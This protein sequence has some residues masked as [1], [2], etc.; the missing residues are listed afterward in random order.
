M[1]KLNMSDLICRLSFLSCAMMSG[2]LFAE[3]VVEVDFTRG[4]TEWNIRDKGS[5][6]GPLPDRVS[7]DFP[8]WNTSQ[9]ISK[10]VS[11]STGSGLRLES[12]KLDYLIL[13]RLANHRGMPFP[14]Y[15]RVTVR[16]RLGGDSAIRLRS[17]NGPTYPTYAIV[18]L[19]FSA[20]WTTRSI[21][22][23]AVD[24]IGG[25]LPKSF[26]QKGILQALLETGTRPIELAFLRIDTASR[27]EYSKFVNRELKRPPKYAGNYLRSSC[28]PLGIPSGWRAVN[29]DFPTG[30]P[31]P[32]GF[33]PLQLKSSKSF[34]YSA[35]FLAPE[36]VSRCTLSFDCRGNGK[37]YVLIVNEKNKPVNTSN[38]TIPLTDSWTRRSI[39]FEVSEGIRGYSILMSGTAQVDRLTVCSTEQGANYAT[40]LRNEVAL[41]P[42]GGKHAAM[43]LH[44]IDETPQ[45]SY[46]VTG[47]LTP[48]SILKGKVVNLYGE[49]R[50]LPDIALFGH[51]FGSFDYLLFPEKQLGPFRI[52]AWVEEKGRKSSPCGELVMTRIRRPVHENHD[53]PN[54]PFGNHVNA[55]QPRLAA[56][57]AAGV[58]HIRLHDALF[59]TVWSRMEA[60]KGKWTFDDKAIDEYRREHLL[61]L[62]WLGGTPRWAAPPNST[63][64]YYG[65]G[66][67]WGGY[68]SLRDEEAFRNYVRKVV[69][70][71][72]GRIHEWDCWNEPWFIPEGAEKFARLQKAACEEIKKVA[73]EVKLVGFNTNAD[74]ANTPDWTT[75]I[76]QQGG[77]QTCD[78][79]DYHIYE[80]SFCGYPGDT[81]E[82]SFRS[83]WAGVLSREKGK[84]KPIYMSEGNWNSRE[85]D[86]AGMYLHSITWTGRE[87]NLE[88]SNGLVRFHLGLL[89]AGCSRIYLYSDQHQQHLLQWQ[90]YP[91][92]LMNDGY[93]RPTL[94]AYSNMAYLLE[95]RTITRK[96]A[97]SNGVWAIWFSG[98]GKT[99]AVI[100]GRQSAKWSGAFPQKS[101]GFD[102]FGNPLTGTLEYRDLVFYL[103]ADSADQELLPGGIRYRP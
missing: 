20:D 102:L 60:E 19:P 21:P 97:L 26:Q 53:A 57:K 83:A 9:A 8:K 38:G 74:Y 85:K 3:T 51:P 23:V 13:F 15:Y 22:V 93:P 89:L 62:G 44:F 92:L 95:D 36:G 48:D 43:R 33:P 6:S 99:V 14:G 67:G 24:E 30:T 78:S 35:P 70:H 64:D 1:S 61:I 84:I 46:H 11:S 28:F 76:Y 69:S 7:P 34:V 98:K 55:A 31:G 103:M 56:L 4:G 75:R 87:N 18:T 86:G 77:Y 82:Q 63:R 49:E 80:S 100:T 16:Y 25:A 17:P 54:S 50:A 72:R 41:A 12:R 88:S 5:F 37:F 65:W 81:L 101:T 79:M 42:R 45:L 29:I 39:E 40:A 71:Y 2:A 68:Y 10:T 27:E 66:R 91:A 32:S 96:T 94:A 59:S 73:P 47:P 52:E 58:N 90:D